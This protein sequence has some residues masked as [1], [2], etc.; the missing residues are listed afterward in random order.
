PAGLPDR[1]RVV[2]TKWMLDGTPVDRLAV[3]RAPYADRPDWTGRL[4]LSPA[5][6]R[7]MLQA[8]LES[9]GQTA[10]HVVGDSTLALV[11]R[12]M[13]E[14]APAETWRA[15]RLRIEHGDGAMPDLLPAMRDLGV[16]L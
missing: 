8:A 3:L 13:R 12:T 7:A 11:L 16:V 4:N 2:G 15:R 6:V 14:L 10:L 1:F 9:D 5:E